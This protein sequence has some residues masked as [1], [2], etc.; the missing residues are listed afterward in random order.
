VISPVFVRT[1]MT[2]N[3]A[4]ASDASPIRLGITGKLG[5]RWLGTNIGRTKRPRGRELAL[6]EVEETSAP[7]EHI[8]AQAKL[9]RGTC[10]KLLLF[11][12]NQCNP[13]TS[14]GSLEAP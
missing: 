11:Q 4:G 13:D 1:I 10:A 6:S 9:E 7:H 5:S 14:A 2:K 12:A 3:M 8:P